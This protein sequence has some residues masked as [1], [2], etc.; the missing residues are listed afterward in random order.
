[1]A[2]MDNRHD[3]KGAA[4]IAVLKAEEISVERDIRIAKREK[5]QMKNYLDQAPSEKYD[6]ARESNIRGLDDEVLE[7]ED[8]LEKI[9]ADKAALQAQYSEKSML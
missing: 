3:S 4:E 2:V 6:A 5:R 1:M 8:D 7:L 9:R